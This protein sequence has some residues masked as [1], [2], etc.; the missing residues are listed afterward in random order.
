MTEPIKR[1]LLSW[2]GE[3]EQTYFI[4]IDA[5]VGETHTY[6]NT[7]TDHPIEGGSPITDHVRPDP[8]R[9]TIQGVI[10]NAPQ[11]LPS[12]NVDGAQLTNR[13][14]EVHTPGIRRIT[15]IPSLGL[16]GQIVQRSF[17][18]GKGPPQGPTGAV[19]ARFQADYQNAAKVLTFSAE[20]NRVRNVFE[21]LVTLWALGTSIRVE[22]ELRDYADMVIESLTVPRDPGTGDSL[23]FELSLKQ[24]KV[25]NSQLVAA[26]KIDVKRKPKGTVSTKDATATDTQS[27]GTILTAIKD[28]FGL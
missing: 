11:F 17:G 19:L 1:T 22:T 8:V 15:P 7:V 2:V 13:T 12:D 24:I 3:G 6:A 18:I 23:Q 28:A 26:P 5:T 9:L 21:E 25:A 20:F 27:S 4:R 16:G 10:S 14:I